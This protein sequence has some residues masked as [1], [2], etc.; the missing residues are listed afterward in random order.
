[1]RE[2]RWNLF[3]ILCSVLLVTTACSTVS[4]EK[5]IGILTAELPE[6]IQENSS[7]PMS[8]Q[9]LGYRQ[10]ESSNSLQ[11]DIIYGLE[12]PQQ[13]DVQIAIRNLVEDERVLAVVGAATDEAS[14]RTAALANFFNLPVV[15]PSSVADN[16]LPSNNLWAFRLSAPGSAHADFLFESVV[17][18]QAL[19]RAAELGSFDGL[20]VAIIYEQNTFGESAAVAAAKAAM[21]QELEIGLYENFDPVNSDDSRLRKLVE[22]VRLEQIKLVY[23]IINDPANAIRLIQTMQ[24]MI[25][26]EALPVLIGQAGGFSSKQFL[27]SPQAGDVFVVQQHIDYD[28]CPISTDGGITQ[29]QSYAAVVLLDHA[30]K[31]AQPPENASDIWSLTGKVAEKDFLGS[32][33]EAVRDALKDSTINLPCLGPVAFDNMGQNQDI[34]FVL[35]KVQDGIAETMSIDNFLEVLWVR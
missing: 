13:D 17:N 15:I 2:Q 25:P 20:K 34:Q 21:K 14:M 33:R 31:I 9:I 1:M 24:N 11:V 23:L 30:L 5:N 18:K 7:S 22:S 32:Y 35:L 3:W 28:T 16:I 6:N 27:E 12:G 8:E 29:A 4:V 19:Q 26:S 10:A